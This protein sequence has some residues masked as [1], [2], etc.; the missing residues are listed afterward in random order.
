MPEERD[1]RMKFN[2][3]AE[4][5]YALRVVSDSLEYNFVM[6]TYLTSLDGSRALSSIGYPFKISPLN[7]LVSLPSTISV[8]LDLGLAY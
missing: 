4:W 8:G 3:A 5:K 2:V 7:E 1:A 6:S